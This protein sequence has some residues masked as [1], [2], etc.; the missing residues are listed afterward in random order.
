MLIAATLLV[1]AAP[2]A[3]AETKEPAA[4][5]PAREINVGTTLVALEDVSLQRAS[6]SK[7]AR[8]QVTKI[9]TE[10][11][12]VT[13]VDVELADGHVIKRVSIDTISKAFA[14]ADE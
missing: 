11:G 7:G 8:V 2:D 9:A 4:S 3:H 10:K 13:S 14:V 1:A 5:E 12:R 6:L